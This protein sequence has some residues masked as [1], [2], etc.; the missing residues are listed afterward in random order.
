M[1]VGNV[2]MGFALIALVILLICGLF[3]CQPVVDGP[4]E[5]P[6][7][8]ECEE[9]CPVPPKA[10]VKK[11]KKKDDEGLFKGPGFNTGPR[12]TPSGKFKV[13]PGFDF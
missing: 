2:L 7:C 4:G 10:T 9:V 3:G 5:N 6:N 12:I 11:K 8:E 13:A 1:K